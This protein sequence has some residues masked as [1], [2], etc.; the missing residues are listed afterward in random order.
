MRS[1]EATN[2][3]PRSDA[4][5][6]ARQGALHD[7]DLLA[8]EPV[9]VLLVGVD[10]D[11]ELGDP[12]GPG[13]GGA[14]VRAGLFAGAWGLPEDHVAAAGLGEHDLGA[15]LPAAVED[16]VDGGAAPHAGPESGSFH[17]VGVGGPFVAETG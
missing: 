3:P 16:D 1:T 14:H 12:C 5:V 6:A 9:G 10:D 15:V 8:A 13:G 7:A 17:D 4:V 11:L 2:R